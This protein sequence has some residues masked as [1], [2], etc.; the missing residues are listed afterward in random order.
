[1]QL[2]LNKAYSEYISILIIQFLM[3]DS[4]FPLVTFMRY[5]AEA[6]DFDDP[7]RPDKVIFD[8]FDQIRSCLSPLIESSI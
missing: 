6:Y 8:T 2:R 5:M 7:D 4:M 1:M 3:V